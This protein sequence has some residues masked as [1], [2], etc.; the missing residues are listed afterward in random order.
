MAFLGGDER[1]AFSKVKAHLPAEHRQRAGPGAIVF[2]GAVLEHMAHQVEVGFHREVS[3][4]VLQGRP[5]PAHYRLMRW[6]RRVRRRKTRPAAWRA[7]GRKCSRKQDGSRC[8]PAPPA[9]VGGNALRPA[10]SASRPAA[11]TGG[12]TRRY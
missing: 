4:R 2:P 6:F 10:P 9:P 3:F 5:G 7:T 12:R 1:E 11:W 8:C